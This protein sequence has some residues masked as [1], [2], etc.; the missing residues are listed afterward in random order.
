MSDGAVILPVVPSVGL[1][2]FGT[3]ILGSPYIFDVRWNSR[4]FAWYMDVLEIDET[5]IVYGIKI[6]L[7]VF[8]GRRSRHKLFTQGVL[9][10]GDSSGVDRE[11]TFDDLGTRIKLIYIPVVELMTRV[12]Q[13]ATP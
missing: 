5:P 6:V 11:A 2:R 13:A 8:L 1:Y 7:G 12:A 3:S 10:A 4:E 9:I